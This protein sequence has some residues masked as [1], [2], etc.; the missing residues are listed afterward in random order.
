M[1]LMADPTGHPHQ[2][3]HRR[4]GDPHQPGGGIHP[5]VAVRYSM[6]DTAYGS[7]G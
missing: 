5:A 7:G 6:T 2:T 1:Q 4:L 3:T